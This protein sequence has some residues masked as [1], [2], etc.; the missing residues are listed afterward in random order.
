MYTVPPNHGDDIR[1]ESFQAFPDSGCGAH[2]LGDWNSRAMNRFARRVLIGGGAGAIG[3]FFLASALPALTIALVLGLVLGAVF[4][5]GMLPAR[6]GYVDRLMSGAA[7][8]IPLWGLISVIGIPL[9]SGTMPEWGA[10][11]M[12]THLPALVGW[13]MYGQA[14]TLWSPGFSAPRRNSPRRLRRRSMC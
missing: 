8:G 6:E 12:R 9:L 11:Q 14:A 3:T 7:M 2:R 5:L 1:H 10:A 13:I 4:A